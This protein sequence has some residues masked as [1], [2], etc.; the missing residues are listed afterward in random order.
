V[1]PS[2]EARW[3]PFAEVGPED[4]QA[5][6]GFAPLILLVDDCSPDRSAYRDHLVAAGYRILTASNGSEALSIAVD[7]LPDLIVRDLEMP[8]MDGWQAARLLNE[9]ERTRPIPIIALS[10]FSGASDV[11]RA[12]AAGCREFLPKPCAAWRLERVIR[13]TLA[14]SR[15]G[16]SGA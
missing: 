3:I 9:H 11:M 16:Q 14:G 8:V 7:A 6:V 4:T 15:Q 2:L 13:S 5:R 12:L 1:E 10:G